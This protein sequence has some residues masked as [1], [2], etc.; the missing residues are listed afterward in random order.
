MLKKSHFIK[1]YLKWIP[2]IVGVG[3]S[4]DRATFEFPEKMCK[5]KKH[6][7]ADERLIAA[8]MV[9]RFIS[10]WNKTTEAAFQFVVI[11]PALF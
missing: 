6:Q 7:D 10:C 4:Y 2:K 11:C 3:L 1:S 8:F 9:N 5:K